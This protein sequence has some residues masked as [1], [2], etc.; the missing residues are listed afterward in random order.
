MAEYRFNVNIKESK[1]NIEFDPNGEFTNSADIYEKL[2]QLKNR[3]YV[4]NDIIVGD[5]SNTVSLLALH[6]I[7]ALD[8][9]LKR[10]I[11]VNKELAPEK[12]YYKQAW[13]ELEEGNKDEG[14]WAM[15]FV[16][17]EGDET[18][19]R[20]SYLTL[21][22]ADLLGEQSSYKEYEPNLIWTLVW[23]WPNYVYWKKRR[24]IFA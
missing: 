11:A 4:E 3:N 12:S 16:G 2:H 22:V 13:L 15:A 6:G 20:L 17:S 9:V 19:T 18:K 21:R 1:L 5:E 7:T 14:I 24:A 23:L 8:T 10:Y